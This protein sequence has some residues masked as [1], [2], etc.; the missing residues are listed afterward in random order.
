MDH[1]LPG[2]VDS[3]R[4]DRTSALGGIP[5]RAA[6]EAIE[7]GL[8]EGEAA[9]F[10]TNVPKIREVRSLPAQQRRRHQR[11]PGSCCRT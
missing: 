7:R 11:A 10:T 6:L 8:H 9:D 1:D 2:R 3:A 5:E 4:I